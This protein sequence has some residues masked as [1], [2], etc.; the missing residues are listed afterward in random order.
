MV[1]NSE[2]LFVK[3]KNAMRF[4]IG[5]LA[6]KLCLVNAGTKLTAWKEAS[7]GANRNPI[8]VEAKS[9]CKSDVF[10]IVLIIT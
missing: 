8:G 10:P 7:Y 2:R 1:R 5:Q 4:R 6:V 9:R 3:R